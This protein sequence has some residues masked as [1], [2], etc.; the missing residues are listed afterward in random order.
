MYTAFKKSEN[1]NNYSS[2]DSVLEWFENIETFDQIGDWFES[3]GLQ[4]KIVNGTC[5]F[6]QETYRVALEYVNAYII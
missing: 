2:M 6:F 5:G 4:D 3:I 1:K